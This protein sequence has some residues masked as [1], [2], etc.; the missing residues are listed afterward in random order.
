MHFFEPTPSSRRQNFKMYKRR[1]QTSILNGQRFY[2]PVYKCALKVQL[3][4]LCTYMHVY[5]CMCLCVCVIIHIL[6]SS[7]VCT[8][9]VHWNVQITSLTQL[10]EIDIA[11]FCYTYLSRYISLIPTDTYTIL[12]NLYRHYLN[13]LKY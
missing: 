5:V 6:V 13:A 11:F 8:G 10:T 9:D 2:P 12:Y 3:E 1:R 4:C 7:L